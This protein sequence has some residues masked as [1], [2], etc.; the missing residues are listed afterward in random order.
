MTQLVAFGGSTNGSAIAF[1]GPLNI[2]GT[3][4]TK[5]LTVNGTSTVSLAVVKQS[6]PGHFLTL[7]TNAASLV[8]CNKRVSMARSVICQGAADLFTDTTL[9][10]AVATVSTSSTVSLRRQVNLLRTIAINSLTSISSF[11]QSGSMHSTFFITLTANITSSVH[12]TKGLQVIKLAAIQSQATV[13]KALT[14]TLTL[15]TASLVS[16]SSRVPNAKLTLTVSVASA[17]S[18]SA[19]VVQTFTKVLTVS[20]SSLTQCFHAVIRHGAGG[21]GRRHVQGFIDAFAR[22]MGK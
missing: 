4:F 16:L 1:D 6:A 17:V 15:A 13:N 12:L 19:R 20:T 2:G 8:A 11:I 7:T 9:N 22:L 10:S 3:Q 18:L 14:R 5:A 21:A